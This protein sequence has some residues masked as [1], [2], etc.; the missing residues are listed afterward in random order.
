MLFFKTINCFSDNELNKKRN[1][2]F[3]NKRKKLKNKNKIKK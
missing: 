2:N 1:M 3:L